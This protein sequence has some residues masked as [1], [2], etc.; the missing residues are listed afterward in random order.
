MKRIIGIVMILLMLMSVTVALAGADRNAKPDKTDDGLK[1]FEKELS[2]VAGDEYVPD[3]IIVKFKPGVGKKKIDEINLRHGTS[4]KRAD[5]HFMRLNV[6]KGK[7]VT[8]MVE[9]YSRN[10][11]IEYA[12][13][14]Y[15]AHALMVPNDHYYPLQWHLDNA[16]YGGINMEDA[17]DISTGTGV[18]VAIIDTGIAYENYK[19]YKQAPDL[20]GTHF[21]AGYDFVNNDEHPNDDNSHGTH[22]AGT[23]AQRTNNNIGVA[24][25]AFNAEIMPVKVLNQDGSGSYADVAEGIRWAADKG[26]K[27]ISMSL[28]GPFPSKTVEEALVY[29][30]GKGVTIIASSGNSGSNSYSCPAAYDAYV[31]AVGA[32]RYDETRASYSSYYSVTNNSTIRQYVDITAPGG[33]T[34]VDQNGDGYGDGVLQNTFNP[35]T[36]NPRDFGYWFFQGTSMAAPHVSGVAALL[37]ANGVTGPDNVREALESTAEDKGDTGW[38]PE[39]GWGI[40]D[41]YAALNYFAVPNE[42]PVADAGADQTALVN[43]NV[44]FNG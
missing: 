21:V 10:P 1:I 36:K 3:E 4:I 24:G 28:G 29:A 9:A 33:N 43:E 16:E 7:T 18:I 37:I 32:T 25:V 2:A 23:V 5:A 15:I 19:Q 14:N 22:V 35:N 27:V 44:T 8:Q 39:Y 6:P 30:Y 42:S 17:W 26:A 38:D 12:E 13:P 31:I 20:A 34:S 40:V 41:A 11:N